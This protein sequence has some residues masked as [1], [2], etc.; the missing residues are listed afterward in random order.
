MTQKRSLLAVLL[1]VSML[2]AACSAGPSGR[3]DVAVEQN[4]PG[5]PEES[6]TDAKPENPELQVPVSDL[7]WTE[8]T[9][10]TFDLY[11]LTSRTPGVVLE[12]A[13][14]EA[15]VDPSGQMFGSFSVGALRAKLDRTPPDAAP[16]VFTSGSDRA[17]IA[18]L[19]DLAAGA[20]TTMLEAHPLVA[21][22]RRGIGRS[23]AIDCVKADTR[24]TRETLANL[25]QFAVSDGDAADRAV[26]VGRDATIECTDLLQPQEIAFATSYAAGDLEQ[27]RIAWGVDTLGIVGTGNGAFTALAYA[28]QYPDR[29]A[30]LILDSPTGVN[31]DQMTVAQQKTEGREAAF[32]AF[33]QRCQALQCSLGSDP[34]GAVSELLA[35]VA[36]GDLA[37]L[38]THAVLDGIAY[39]LASSS[40]DP[41][42][43]TVELAD[44]LSRALSG[45]PS[46]LSQ[47]S[48][49]GAVAYGTDGQFVARCIDGQQ[50]PSPQSVRDAGASWSEQYPI[51]GTD[52][53]LTALT[54][55]SWPTTPAP[56][57]PTSLS[58]PVLELS[59][60]GDPVVGNG[61]F[62]SVTGLVAA[63]GARSAAMTWQGAGHPVLGGS[64]CAQAA[65]SAYATDASLPP[66]G[67]VCPA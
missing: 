18:T 57:L 56:P 51:F 34:K 54:C 49:R 5:Q 28:A 33:L 27:L 62:A 14:F 58:V 60:A 67:S 55:S 40:G 52:A 43:R 29:V 23:T 53:A 2:G 19:A 66:D 59:G 39:A 6:T 65:A 1:T 36:S 61:G 64:V 63:T 26:A 4:S 16:L 17:S 9:Q 10:S 3:P 15:P 12:C 44:A 32:T 41:S 13:D 50:W 38:S 37:P 47:L 42:R 25:G 31:V 11:G 22:D 30:R 46:A 20:S 48:S 35:Q 8:C 45:D 21:V 7:A 24:K